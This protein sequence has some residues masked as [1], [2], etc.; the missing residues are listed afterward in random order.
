MTSKLWFARILRLLGTA[1]V[2][3]FLLA[4][5]GLFILAPFAPFAEVSGA[6]LIVFVTTVL[7][8]V[9]GYLLFLAGDWISP[10]D[11][12]LD[13][14]LGTIFKRRQPTT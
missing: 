14:K 12:W 5:V 8:A 9:P 3:P 10:P 7:L 13:R 11:P 4:F 1:L 2:G 6:Y